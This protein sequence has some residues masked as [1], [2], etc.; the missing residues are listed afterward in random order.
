MHR[1]R[2]LCRSSN[3]YKYFGLKLLNQS[4]NIE[5]KDVQI[6]KSEV[7]KRKLINK[8]KYNYSKS[9]NFS[10]I[11][12]LFNEL[13]N[14]E[15]NSLSILNK[16]IIESLCEL[17]NI[18]AKFIDSTVFGNN[19]LRGYVRVIDICKLLNAKDY[20]NLPGGVELYDPSTFN[21]EDISLKFID[22]SNSLSQLSILHN[23]NY[24]AKEIIT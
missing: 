23:F 24:S 6:D 17:L 1:N 12:Y 9:K 5:I 21:K 18:K 10:N 16:K 4:S 14:T 2:Y 20:Y 7:H 22:N 11:F 3:D 13:I 19:N 8:I 15:T